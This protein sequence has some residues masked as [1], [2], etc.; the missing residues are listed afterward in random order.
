[1]RRSFKK[2][3]HEVSEIR[4]EKE[5]NF[6][7]ELEF[8]L[9]S[10]TTEVDELRKPISKLS[11][12]V[13]ASETCPEQRS[14]IPDGML[15]RISNGLGVECKNTALIIYHLGISNYHWH[16]KDALEKRT[17]LSAI[18]IDEVSSRVPR[19]I[20]KGINKSGITVYCFANYFFGFLTAPLR[21]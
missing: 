15:E 8:R 17:G 11:Y 7:K 16:T 6:N 2:S 4:D 3:I 14:S 20:I 21:F 13:Q 5:K 12:G 19:L 18:T 9:E 10:I 1:M